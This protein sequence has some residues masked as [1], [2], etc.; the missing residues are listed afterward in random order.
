MLII[1][2]FRLFTLPLPDLISNSPNCVP[3]SYVGSENLVL[4]LINSSIDT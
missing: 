1:P 3:Y 4:Y 2:F